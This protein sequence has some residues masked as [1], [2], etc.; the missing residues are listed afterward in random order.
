MYV[1]G[2]APPAPCWFSDL[3]LGEE[4]LMK[5]LMIL[6]GAGALAVSTAAYA[7]TT[8]AT[9]KS[10]TPGAMK[11]DKDVPPASQSMTPT[12]P[13]V[14]QQ[15][16]GGQGGGTAGTSGSTGGSAAGAASGSEGASS[17]GAAGGGA[18]G[19]SR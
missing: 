19:A 18:G 2:T 16:G 9:P 1:R 7:Q 12:S 5:K 11:S 8:P 3:K 4:T 17:G 13:S 15:T 6:I 10:T 14:G